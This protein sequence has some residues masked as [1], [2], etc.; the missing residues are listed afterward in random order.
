MVLYPLSMK[1]TY[2]LLFLSF[3]IFSQ[4]DLEVKFHYD[5]VND[6]FEI[7]VDNN[8]YCEV[9]AVLQ[10]S[11]EN[12]TVSS[13]NKD[14]FIIPPR[15]KNLKL[16]EL[17]A[18]N[19]GKYG[20][21]FTHKEYRGDITKTSYS[22]H[23]PYSLPYLKGQAYKVIQADNSDLS[24]QNIRPIDFEMPIGTPITA[25]RSGIVVKVEDG[26]DKHGETED[27]AN[28]SNHIILMHS[29]GT[30]AIYGHL[31][32]KSSKVKAGDT[33]NRDA[34]IALSGD[35]GWTNV[36]KLHVEVYRPKPAENQTIEIE[37]KVGF[38][39]STILL[40]ENQT[41]KKDY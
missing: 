3:P 5:K 34:I 19:Y 25:I 21:E 31:K 14:T 10:L 20:F 7:F 23:Y 15:T 6:S 11:H 30:F 13:K 29:D 2:I 9:T 39:Q 1:L 17:T 18:I 4:N 12:V 22:N 33:V 26:F 27:F 41:Y 38:G 24:H 8:E 32:Q 36:P 40:K 37:F 16:S 28:F 35:T